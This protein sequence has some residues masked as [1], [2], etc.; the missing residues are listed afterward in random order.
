MDLF[1]DLGQCMLATYGAVTIICQTLDYF[2]DKMEKQSE[3]TQAE[4]REAV[5]LAMQERGE[6]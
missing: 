2:T 6:L 5:R 1:L 4:I 3:K